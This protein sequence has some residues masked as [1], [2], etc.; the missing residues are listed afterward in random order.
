M[1]A[2]ATIKVRQS[3]EGRFTLEDRFASVKAK[4]DGYELQHAGLESKY[5][6]AS[7]MSSMRGVYKAKMKSAKGFIKYYRS[8]YQ[9]LKAELNYESPSD[10]SDGDSSDDDMRR[11][12]GGAAAASGEENSGGDDASGDEAARLVQEAEDNELFDLTSDA[13]E[14]E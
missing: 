8:L 6:S 7:K 4:L 2:A 3:M 14:E 10:S 5:Q 9:E 12:V 11:I 1:D 13:E